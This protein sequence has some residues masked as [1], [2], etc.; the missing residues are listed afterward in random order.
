[1]VYISRQECAILQ[2]FVVNL[3]YLTTIS[4]QYSLEKFSWVLYTQEYFSK[5]I[6]Q[7]MDFLLNQ[8]LYIL[9]ILKDFDLGILLDLTVQV[10]SRSPYLVMV[11][12]SFSSWRTNYYY[13][14]V[15]TPQ[16]SLYLKCTLS[17][18][19]S[20]SVIVCWYMRI[21]VYLAL[22][23]SRDTTIGPFKPIY[24]HGDLAHHQPKLWTLNVYIIVLCHLP[25]ILF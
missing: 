19:L 24:N 12:N 9:K 13:I 3:V 25:I 23:I 17:A 22:F 20:D 11:I 7:D 1:M 18:K 10:Y 15:L 4:C 21:E 5:W 14:L 16:L 8:S 2:A 6:W